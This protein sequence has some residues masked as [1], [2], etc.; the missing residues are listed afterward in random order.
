MNKTFAHN[1]RLLIAV[2]S[3]QASNRADAAGKMVTAV[4]NAS[5]VAEAQQAVEHILAFMQRI[6]AL[7]EEQYRLKQRT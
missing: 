1:D 6:D 3:N 7:H 5:S 4:K 2:L